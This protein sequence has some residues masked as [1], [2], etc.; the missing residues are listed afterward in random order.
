MK[1]AICV[2]MVF[3]MLAPAPRTFGQANGTAANSGAET[4]LRVNSRAVL[5][6]V[7]VTDRKGAPV[8]GLPQSAFSVKEQGKPQGI[9]FF[10]EHQILNATEQENCRAAPECIQQSSR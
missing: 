7:L 1:R 5:V 8:R 4:T 2:A 10:E 6:D 9:T 3:L